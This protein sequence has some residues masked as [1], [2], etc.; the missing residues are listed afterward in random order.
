MDVTGA[1]LRG[2]IYIDFKENIFH[3]EL[4]FY[5]YIRVFIYLLERHVYLVC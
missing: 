3:N 1:I 4:D 2:S 5:P